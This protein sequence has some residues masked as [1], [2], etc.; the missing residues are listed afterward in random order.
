MPGEAGLGEAA[1]L[2][3]GPWMP[4]L[5]SRAALGSGWQWTPFHPPAGE[6]LLQSHCPDEKAEAQVWPER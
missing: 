1:W 3:S 6:G 5:M 4:T 2:A